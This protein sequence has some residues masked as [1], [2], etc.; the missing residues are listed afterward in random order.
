MDGSYWDDSDVWFLLIFHYVCIR[1]PEL[2][3]ASLR[4]IELSFSSLH[5]G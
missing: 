4:H 5:L 2:R 1:V 3:L